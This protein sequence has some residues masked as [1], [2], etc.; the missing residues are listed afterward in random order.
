MV[1]VSDDDWNAN[2]VAVSWIDP[3]R[4]ADCVFQED[5][6]KA[7][8]VRCREV[9]STS[10]P[11]RASSQDTT[12][13]TSAT[14]MVSPAAVQSTWPIDAST[15]MIGSSIGDVDVPSAM[16]T[17][18]LTTRIKTAASSSPAIADALAMISR[19]I[20]GRR[21]NGRSCCATLRS[22]LREPT[23]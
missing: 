9:S 23:V 22:T 19:S 8:I 1:I 20:R 11:T 2:V 13:F 17:A 18:P 15:P 3:W 12:V 14:A 21:R 5:P 16:A 7:S 4:S 6:R 10:V